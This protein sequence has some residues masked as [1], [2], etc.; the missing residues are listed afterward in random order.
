M[1]VVGDEGVDG[2]GEVV[3]GGDKSSEALPAHLRPVRLHAEAALLQ[4]H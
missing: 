1:E 4:L 2:A 3:D